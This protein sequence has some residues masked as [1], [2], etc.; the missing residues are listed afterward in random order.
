MEY[1]FSL[2]LI[3]LSKI[4][5]LLINGNLTFYKIETNSMVVV[6]KLIFLRNNFDNSKLN[7]N[8]CLKI[9]KHY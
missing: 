3:F 2:P 8:I 5:F 4:L 7:R 9:R 1:F 6:L